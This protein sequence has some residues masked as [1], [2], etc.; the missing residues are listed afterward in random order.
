MTPSILNTSEE[1]IYYQCDLGFLTYEHL[2]FTSP[3]SAAAKKTNNKTYTL[4]TILRTIDSK[5]HL[6]AF[7]FKILYSS[8]SG[9]RNICTHPFQEK[10]CRTH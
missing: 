2:D 3:F 6:R 7:T 5:L 10:G 4:I 1:P 9:V 8:D